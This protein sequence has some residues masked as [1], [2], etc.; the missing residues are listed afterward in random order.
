MIMFRRL[1]FF[2]LLICTLSASVFS[3]GQNVA[4][5]SKTYNFIPFY[6]FKED[7]LNKLDFDELRVH[8]DRFKG[9]QF[10]EQD[11]LALGNYFS[12][13]PDFLNLPSFKN[14]KGL[15]PIPK[16]G[17]SSSIN[18]DLLIGTEDLFF[19][20]LRSF[21][22]GYGPRWGR[23]H[24]GLD[25]GLVTGDTIR[26]TFNG[27][28]RYAEFNN[29]G[30]GNCVI[31]SHLN[32]LETLYGHLSKITCKPGSFV[33]SGQVIGLGGS[34]GRSTGPHLHLEFRYLGQSIDPLHLIDSVT[35][36]LKSNRF[37]LLPAY[38]KDPDRYI[39][40]KTSQVYKVSKGK[41]KKS[42]RRKKPATSS[43]KKRK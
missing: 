38:L 10:M 19:N 16:A 12:R 24:R 22:W 7:L 14:S 27:V 25:L 31:I 4:D 34:T 28:V 40:Q 17:I 5:S 42:K 43:R 2:T 29:G 36:K 32:G 39:I 20:S 23:M 18:L 9:G 26:S 35:W 1:Y 33:F 37:V 21:N 30:Y 41:N 13:R 3:Y 15:F 6:A 11:L 8:V